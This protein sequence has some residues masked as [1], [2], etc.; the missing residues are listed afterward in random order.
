[1]PCV[2][3]AESRAPIDGQPRSTGAT[4]VEGAHNEITMT[5]DQIDQLLERLDKRL[6]ERLEQNNSALLERI[7][8]SNAAFFG[9]QAQFFKTQFDELRAELATRTDRIYTQLDGLTKRLT[10]DETYRAAI[11]DEQGRHREWIG[12][13]AKATRTKLEPEQ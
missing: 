13:L 10:D 12:Q 8:T 11:T 4:Y 6:D 7:E 2:Q 5:N 3:A 1:M 9:Q